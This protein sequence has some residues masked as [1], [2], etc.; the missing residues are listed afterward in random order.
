MPEFWFED[1]KKEKIIGVLNK[2]RFTLNCNRCHRKE[3]ACI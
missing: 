2:D 1:D 3:G